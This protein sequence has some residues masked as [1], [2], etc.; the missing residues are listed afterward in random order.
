M[1]RFIYL[2]NDT[3]NSYVSQI[4][5][6]LI[7]EKEIE[8]QNKKGKSRNTGVGT[9][10]KGKLNLTV[11]KKGVNAETNSTFEHAFNTSKEEFERNVQTQIMHDNIFDKLLEYL[12]TN[13]MLDG[14]QIGQFVSIQDDF[15]I[16][17]IDFYKKLS[18]E[19]GFIDMISELQVE[20]ANESVDDEYQSL[21]RQQ[22]R[23]KKTQQKVE[24]IKEQN[25]EQA[26]LQRESI[27]KLVKMLDEIIPYPQILCIGKYAVVLN[28]SFL[29][30][31]I[32]TASFK[33]GGKINVVGYITNSISGRNNNQLSEFVVV[34]NAI[35]EVMKVFF[36]N[37]DEMFIVHPIAIYYDN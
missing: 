23:D 17:D 33:Y 32:K 3:L 11:L 2:D 24:E 31:D 34:Q 21:N 36:G 13:N 16:F 15:Y 7:S 26:G 18:R 22:R 12:N 10:L 9:G 37:I 30:D 20:S 29:R 5:D 6:G 35:N 27:E 25:S 19:N 4:Y 1:K 28:E 14:T 8:K